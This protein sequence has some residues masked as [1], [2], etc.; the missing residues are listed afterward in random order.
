MILQST[1]KKKV[2]ETPDIVS[3][4]VET[5]EKTVDLHSTG[6]PGSSYIVDGA[7]FPVRSEIN[8]G[9]L[10]KRL[11]VEGRKLLRGTVQMQ[12]HDPATI[13]LPYL[14]TS[15]DGILHVIPGWSQRE[16]IEDVAYRFKAGQVMETEV[17]FLGGI[18][19]KKKKSY[20]CRGVMVCPKTTPKFRNMHHETVSDSNQVVLNSISLLEE[21]EVMTR[22]ALHIFREV[23][24]KKHYCSAC[25]WS[26]NRVPK[27]CGGKPVI[28][29]KQG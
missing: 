15:P 12:F 20:L 1:A 24:G 6:I 17:S 25:Y 28:Q 22:N 3:T 16:I 10:T 13:S 23:R 5:E 4:H 18:R 2:N 29:K 21:T 26:E 27:T 11:F 7:I 19:C 8:D 9:G 14:D